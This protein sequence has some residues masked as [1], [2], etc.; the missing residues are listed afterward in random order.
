MQGVGQKHGPSEPPPKESATQ[1]RQLLCGVGWPR[2]TP[3]AGRKL[4]GC[5]E[6][7]TPKL[8]ARSGQHWHCLG[9]TGW[10]SLPG[11][12]SDHPRK[13][14]EAEP[15][16][17]SYRLI[18][19]LPSPLGQR[20]PPGS[21]GGHGP[22]TRANYNHMRPQTHEGLG[23]DA[24]MN[25]MY[26]CVHVC[27]RMGGWMSGYMDGWMDGQKDKWAGLL[28]S[29]CSP[30]QIHSPL[31]PPCSVPG[32]Q[33]LPNAS[34]RLPVLWLWVGFGQWEAPSGSQGKE[35]RDARLPH[36]WSRL[37]APVHLRQ[38]QVPLWVPV[39]TPSFA[40]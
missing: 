18:P 13:W 25:G 27:L 5:P 8:R 39:A 15:P 14:A 3:A 1:R 21:E 35:G 9:E 31:S 12:A 28:C 4:R 2:G 17:H 33:S 7:G 23:E 22:P 37:P 38:P 16:A 20:G 19:L 29:V 30:P 40:P 34:P 32:C 6:A 10:E 11:P 26:A 24:G 36:L